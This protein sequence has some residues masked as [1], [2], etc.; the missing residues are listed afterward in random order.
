MDRD[1]VRPANSPS[2]HRLITRKPPLRLASQRANRPPRHC[3]HQDYTH[4]SERIYNDRAGAAPAIAAGRANDTGWRLAGRRVM[5]S[6]SFISDVVNTVRLSN[7][8]FTK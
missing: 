1:P 4:E 3:A 2:G 7:V 8:S 5:C 6:H